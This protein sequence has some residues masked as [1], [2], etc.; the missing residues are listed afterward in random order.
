LGYNEAEIRDAL[1]VVDV[2]RA[3]EHMDNERASRALLASFAPQISPPPGTPPRAPPMPT[4]PPP[5]LVATPL[6][7]ATT[8]MMPAAYYQ[9]P[10]AP[11]AAVASASRGIGIATATPMSMSSS[12]SI[13][14]VVAGYASEEDRVR[15]LALQWQY[16]ESRRYTEQ[17]LRREQEERDKRKA[18]EEAAGIA[19]A[20]QWQAAEAD[21]ATR[22]YL[23]RERARE[24]EGIY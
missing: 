16:E 17:L 12:S 2:N 20:R 13:D 8:P 1:R 9:S 5:V 18:D 10:V 21:G 4:S 14:P 3:F 19:A 11:P 6:S 15:A 24:E 22:D 23:A 7:Y